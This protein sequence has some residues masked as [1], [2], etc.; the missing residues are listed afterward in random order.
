[1]KPLIK[2]TFAIIFVLCLFITSN[3]VVGSRSLSDDN[4]N[5]YEADVIDPDISSFDDSVDCEYA[6][7]VI[8]LKPIGKNGY[9]FDYSFPS[10]ETGIM[11]YSGE[12]WDVIEME[13][14][15]NY[16]APG[17]PSVPV[18]ILSIETQLHLDNV[19]VQLRD[20][21]HFHTK[22][23]PS[24]NCISPY[25]QEELEIV[26]QTM[27][28][29]RR[30]IPEE[31]FN[32]ELIGDK[33]FRGGD[34]VFVYSLSLFP[35]KYNP[36][37]TTAEVFESVTITLEFQEEVEVEV[38]PRSGANYLKTSLV[39]MPGTTFEG[40]SLLFK[41]GEEPSYN[42]TEIRSQR[43]VDL[44]PKYI[45]VTT[46]A[47]ESSLES[48]AEWKT[49]KG[50]PCEIHTVEDIYGDYNGVDNPEKIRN[51][52]I[53]MNNQYNIRYVLLAGDY[54]DV[55]VRL[56]VDP[57]PADGWD[58]GWIP[59]D[60]YYACL[61]GT[62]DADG[63]GIW[64]EL[65][66]ITDRYA[67]VYLS[68]IAIHSFSIMNRWASE[69]IDYE[70]NP[71]AGNWVEKAIL[72]GADAHN[73]GD[74]AV[75]CEYLYDNYLDTTFTQT[76]K[77]Y[78]NG[79]TISRT[80][81]YNTMCQGSSYVNFIDHGGPTMWL[82][83]GGNQLVLYNQDVAAF[84]NGN[85]KPLVTA[86]AC[87]TAWF[88]DPSGCGYEDF[89][90]CIGEK[91]TEDPNDGAIAY[92]GSSRSAVAVIG[93]NEYTYGAGGLQEDICAQL[94]VG[95]THLGE[96]YIA[97]MNHYA[98]AFGNWFA[99]PQ[100]NQIQTCWLELNMLGEPE[101]PLWTNTPKEMEYVIEKTPDFFNISVHES[102]TRNK[103]SGA[104][105]C[106]KSDDIYLTATTNNF[107]NAVLLNPLS[108]ETASLT[109]TKPN[110]IPVETEITFTDDIPPVTEFEI[111]PHHPTGLSGYYNVTPT[112][113]MSTEQWGNIY[114]S[115]DGPDGSYRVYNSPL[116]LNDG[117]Y[118]I[119][120]YAVDQWDNQEAL[121]T[122]DV[123]VDTEP[124]D[125]IFNITPSKPNGA[126]MWYNAT[127]IIKL[128]TEEDDTDIY[129]RIVSENS[130]HE[131]FQEYQAPFW[132]EDEGILTFEY[133][134]IDKAGNWASFDS[135]EIR[136][137][138][139]PPTASIE[140]DEPDGNNSWYVTVPEITL[141]STD[142]NDYLY[143]YFDD[144]IDTN[145]Y[146]GP[147]EPEEGNH[148]L[149]FYSQD[150][151]GNRGP[152]Q[153]F[154][155][156][157][158]TTPPDL[159]LDHTPS[160]PDGLNGYYITSPEITFPSDG[161]TSVYYSWN[162]GPLEM[163][164]NG[165]IIAPPAEGLNELQYFAEDIAG[166]KMGTQEA[167]FLVDVTPTETRIICDPDEPDGENDWYTSMDIKIRTVDSSSAS[168]YY[169]FDNSENVKKYSRE[170]SEKDIPEGKHVL[171]HYC[172]DRAGNIGPENQLEIW[173][174]ATKPTSVVDLSDKELEKGEK[175]IVLGH[176]SRDDCSSLSYKIDFGDGKRTTF[177]T[178][179]NHTHEYS[180]GGKYT[181]TLWVRDEAGHISS[182]RRIQLNVEEEGSFGFVSKMKNDS[183]M[184]FWGLII[185]LPLL[186][187]IIMLFLV[188]LRR[189]KKGG[190]D[191]PY[192]KEEDEMDLEYNT[193]GGTQPDPFSQGEAGG[194]QAPN[195]GGPVLQD[196]YYDSEIFQYD[197][198]GTDSSYPMNSAPPNTDARSHNYENSNYYQGHEAPLNH[199]GNSTDSE[200]ESETGPGA[201][202]GVNSVESG[203]NYSLPGPKS[204]PFHGQ[205]PR[206][207]DRDIKA[208]P[209]N[210]ENI[211]NMGN[212][213]IEA[214]NNSAMN[215][216]EGY[217]NKPAKPL[218]PPPK[219]LKERSPDSSQKSSSSVKKEKSGDIENILAGLTDTLQ[220]KKVGSED[221]LSNDQSKED[222]YSWS[223]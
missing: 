217:E 78:E 20:P 118:S 104:V 200:I 137:D 149:Y 79:G 147:F 126:M 172:V 179:K 195:G 153:S 11:Q 1:M 190:Y 18:Q 185:G 98:Q 182:P 139:T 166:N 77:F 213:H 140:I 181:I 141:I 130:N 43:D 215:I 68:R 60:K 212:N 71:P 171:H 22:L 146:T 29:S 143:Y 19:D 186:L 58:D 161:N 167:S 109:M 125:T 92:I 75:Q 136:I 115:L 157:I 74:G 110:F 30:F 90:E 120:Y 49:K 155:M 158:D 174:D 128:S 170:I 107:G 113:N 100:H 223:I 96:V 84:T 53:D 3:F 13:N 135:T 191:Q 39:T 159:V 21:T 4:R 33:I 131:E 103:V 54:I 194:G 72:I 175:V 134:N 82:Q 132:P 177:N 46:N 2:K 63:D 116:S 112:I 23:V 88:D 164:V 156:K 80:N 47:L 85:K 76:E 188:L 214:V 28:S 17:Y 121:R 14:S 61:G 67:D 12:I 101:V 211:G 32:F 7:S 111:I 56:C 193:E 51:F 196:E 42:S 25:S 218:P 66:D 59:A 189:K 176:K 114:Y 31:D 203:I 173:F 154:S 93:I 204:K 50:V 97:G 70:Q 108:Q 62:W 199:T 210:T 148:T 83:N 145:L 183:P 192:L 160:N 209:E 138:T 40:N 99:D 8:S 89:S 180:K 69:V 64:G 6:E 123:S 169:Y 95:K 216:A 86:M 163:Y 152:S 206:N 55:P 144:P 34:K 187:I 52:L 197:Q 65:G 219:G 26:D 106:L 15:I 168:I 184:L 57:D 102:G 10:M 48:L 124:S 151:A 198:S 5:I 122:F 201:D 119:S 127:P 105:I 222:D 94:G 38:Q 44:D 87:L 73:T 205:L 208:L 81:V 178:V 91:F 16:P 36:A 162:S 9:S 150:R 220:D 37:Q 45:I 202:I 221:D 165:R 117:E 35:V 41:I 129:F 27:Y 133:Y 24:P 142:V 207:S